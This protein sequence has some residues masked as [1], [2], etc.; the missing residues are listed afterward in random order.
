L[1]SR[2]RVERLP[3]LILLLVTVA[4]GHLIALPGNTLLS[5]SIQDALHI[6]AFAVIAS[7]IW[8]SLRWPRVLV[9]LLLCA[10]IG[11]AYEIAQLFTS[12]DASALDLGRD[13]LGAVVVLMGWYQYER[14][15]A[16]SGR[17]WL[18][19]AAILV[20]ISAL[21]LPLYAMLTY[22]HRDAMFPRLLDIG[23][24][25]QQG[26]IRSNSFKQIVSAPADWPEYTG[27]PVL[28]IRWSEDTYP[29]MTLEELVPDWSGYTTLAID[30]YVVGDEPLMFTVA[31]RHVGYDG[32]AA[33]VPNR[34]GPGPVQLRVP[35]SALARDRAGRPALLR[36]LILHT[37]MRYAGREILIGAVRLE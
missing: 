37:S 28:L 5:A 29:G 4:A 12:R 3:W 23:S 10:G 20:L 30:M 31:V 32:T 24:W 1:L 34:I 13:L 6:A 21:V 15:R 18:A 8:L 2:L 27:R 11:A 9:V 7:A 17:L 25:W 22:Q 33:Y 19:G 16:A 36:D 26:L 14:R 35:L